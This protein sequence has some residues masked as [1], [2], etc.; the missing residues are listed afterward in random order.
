MAITSYGAFVG[1]LS[2]L[3]VIGVERSYNEPP[4]QINAGDL[5]IMFPRIPQ[6]SEGGITA[7]GA[8]GWPMMRADLVVL[9]NPAQVDS[10]GPNFDAALKIMDN[11]S[12]A[13]RASTLAKTKTNWSIRTEQAMVGPNLFW[14]IIAEVRTNG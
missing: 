14:A 4:Q 8:G 11:L 13:L 3:I 9:I 10:N 6:G 5:P 7:S 12:V 2:G 1:A